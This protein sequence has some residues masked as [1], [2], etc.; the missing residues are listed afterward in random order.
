MSY[1]TYATIRDRL[2]LRDTDVARMAD[3]NRTTFPQWKAGLFVPKIEKR[4]RI[5]E[6]LGVTVDVLDGLDEIPDYYVDKE[7]QEI[8]EGMHQNKDYQVMFKAIP[9]LKPEDAKMIR[10]MIERLL[11]DDPEP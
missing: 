4:R 2:G 10:D 8:V 1:E 9:K 5:A 3:V 6:A 7:T 11:P